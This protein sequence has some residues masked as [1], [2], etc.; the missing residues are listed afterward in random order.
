VSHK[1]TLFDI[2]MKYGDVLPVAEVLDYLHDVRDGE[3]RLSTTSPASDASAR[4]GAS[5]ASVSLRP[6]V[7]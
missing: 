5:A 4:P 2:H 6:A 1:V 3:H 7:S